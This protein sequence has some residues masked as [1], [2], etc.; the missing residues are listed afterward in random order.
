MPRPSIHASTLAGRDVPGGGYLELELELADE[1]VP[2]IMLIPS[3][4]APAPAAL[5][6]HGF[7]SHKERMAES[8][9]RA[10]LKRQIASLAIDLPL[11]GARDGEFNRLA[12]ASL[13]EI[14]NHWRLALRE[15][16]QAIG[17]LL[18][19][20]AIDAKRVAVIGY[21][22]GSYIAVMA[23]AE[24]PAVRAVVLAAGGDLPEHAMLTPLIRQVANPVQ[25]VQEL[26]GRPLLMVNGRQ[27]TTI[28]AVQAE[29]LFEAAKEPRSMRWYRG[30]HWLPTT[31][32]DYA[33]RWLDE[34]LR[35]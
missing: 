21:S 20:S 35:G 12:G 32:V 26:A 16:R 28:T 10:L 27:D 17:F 34:R 8:I 13:A 22:L 9:G 30:G 5:L 14:V 24:L 33:A 18:E 29:R 31:E 2:A 19:H 4:T 23:A 15:S 25:A 7:A 11:H 1:R 3:G 6:L